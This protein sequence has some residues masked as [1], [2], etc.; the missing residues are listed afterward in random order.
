MQIRLNGKTRE[1]TDGISIRR[2]LD[3]LK[4]DPRRV[5]VQRN[6]DIIK[7][8]QYETVVLQPGDAVEVL[9]IMAG[10]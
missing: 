3:E 6:E 9:T 8:D 7:R 5:A 4:L 1:V 2:L 10:G